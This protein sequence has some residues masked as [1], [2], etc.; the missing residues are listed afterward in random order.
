M[1]SIEH[2]AA[3]SEPRIIPLRTPAGHPAGGFRDLVARLAAAAVAA[4][5]GPGRAAVTVSLDVSDA[6]HPGT[7]IAAL[8]GTLGRL[9]EAACVAAATPPPRGGGPRR[10]EVLVTTVDT[11]DAIEI[12][13]AD[14][15]AAD[16]RQ[17]AVVRDLRP[18][19]ERAGWGLSSCGCPDGGTAV[20]LRIPRR[21]GRSLAA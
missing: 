8:A 10:P 14:S 12:E 3:A 6:H 16:G 1:A 19:A 15:A 21:R 20:T 9:L 13:V 17:E 7:D 4:S 18:L 5:R 11:G 2:D